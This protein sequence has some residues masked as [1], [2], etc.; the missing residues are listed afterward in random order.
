MKI[1]Y[2][3]GKHGV[4]KQVLVDDDDY[5]ILSQYHWYV[6]TYG[7][8]TR[9]VNID[10]KR[11]SIQMHRQIMNA[12][13]DKE[14]DHINHDKLDNR[15]VNLRICTKSQNMSNM[16]PSKSNK[17]GYRGVILNKKTGKWEA[18]ISVDKKKHHLGLYTKL[19]DAV[20]ARQKAAVELHG[21]YAIL[22]SNH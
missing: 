16:Y 20:K 4:D 9:M 17:S 1:I 12:P 10:D 14:V 7:Y 19:E 3:T 6:T 15:K 18:F 22:P 21:D 5:L 2:P 8:A 13:K 11:T